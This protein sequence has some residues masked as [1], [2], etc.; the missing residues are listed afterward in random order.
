MTIH[1]KY[2]PRKHD[3]PIISNNIH[4]YYRALDLDY[5]FN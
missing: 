1:L 3:T 4:I 5:I 2:R